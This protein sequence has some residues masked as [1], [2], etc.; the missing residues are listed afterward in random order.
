M[1]VVAVERLG[2]CSLICARSFIRQFLFRFHV[3]E[4]LRYLGQGFE[5]LGFN[6]VGNPVA[7]AY[8]YLP[9]HHDVEVHVETEAHLPN[10][11]FI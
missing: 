2:M 8:L 1:Y 3:N 5:H 6:S 11:A 4:H 9:I 10:V 7:F